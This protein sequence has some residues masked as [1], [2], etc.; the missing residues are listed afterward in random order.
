MSRKEGIQS[1]HKSRRH[2]ERIAKRRSVIN[3]CGEKTSSRQVD[4]SEDKVEDKCYCRCRC[5]CC[6]C[7][8]TIDEE[9]IGDKEGKPA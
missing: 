4:D 6:S 3:T 1:R 7:I 8:V 9:S 2:Q 5:S